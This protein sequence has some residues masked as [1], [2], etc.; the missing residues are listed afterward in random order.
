ME[1]SEYLTYFTEYCEKADDLMEFGIDVNEH[2]EEKEAKDKK[3]DHD[4][5][6]SKWEKRARTWIFHLRSDHVEFGFE[7]W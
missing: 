7:F 6:F 4:V 1:E 2:K 5:K 3:Q